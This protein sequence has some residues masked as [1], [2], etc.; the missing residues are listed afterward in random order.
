MKK[1]MATF[2][3]FVML[4]LVMPVLAESTYDT[5]IS[6][7]LSSRN[8]RA[9]YDWNSDALYKAITDK[10]NV[11]IDI[12]AVDAASQDDTGSVWILGGSMPN[13]QMWAGFNYSTYMSYIEQDLI[14]ALPEGWEAVYPNLYKMIKATGLS[15]Y[16]NIDGKTYG[17][18]HAV[19]ANFADMDQ[20]VSHVSIYYR[21]DWLAKL[22]MGPWGA[23]VT[24]DEFKTYLQG[25]IDNDLAGT[26]RTVG[27]T[28]NE[29]R[30]LTY[31]MM[32]TGIDFDG[33]NST[34]EGYAWGPTMEGV[35]DVIDELR[36]YYKQGLI[37][38]DY[39]LLSDT[40]AMG[41]FYSGNAAA[42][43][44]SG[45]CS[46]VVQIVDAFKQANDVQDGYAN[47]SMVTLSDNEGVVYAEET[48]NYWTMTLFNPDTDEVTMDRILT[49]VDWLCTEEGQLVTQLGIQ[50]VDWDYG[51]DGELISLTGQTAIT[52]YPSFY[53]FNYLSI[54][55]DDFSFV[56]PAFDP[57][58]QQIVSDI[59]TIKQTGIVIPYNFDYA[60]YNSD[61]KQIYSVDVVGAASKLLLND[62]DIQ[63]EWNSFIDQY[64]L[65]VNPLLAEMN[66]LFPSK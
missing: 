19:F 7:S 50:G 17:I 3:A 44:Y 39:Y 12:W 53:P 52:A 34:P 16:I 30:L 49:M 42:L 15:D 21:P 11:D 20:I 60:F 54:L 66:A 2:L 4:V 48:T 18:P 28:T 27:L 32:F 57:R 61:A 36:S 55:S 40:D 43:I 58:V 56:S 6:F 41:V 14:R 25:C 62:A 47:V 24:I 8:V 29:N 23:S 33:F 31:A 38:P 5:P 22:D 45:S 9:N 59:Y 35:T 65:M 51:E 13:A 64:K 46:G 10:F 1:T 63:T 37:D 26:G